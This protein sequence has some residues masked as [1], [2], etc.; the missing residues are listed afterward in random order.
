M[1]QATV[2]GDAPGVGSWFTVTQDGARAFNA[3]M[4]PGQT[5]TW[6]AQREVF[7]NIGDTSVVQLIVNGQAFPG[8]PGSVPGVPRKMR[9]RPDGCR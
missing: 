4:R 2:M 3:L 7:L 6:R 9:C 8:L 1:V 5:V